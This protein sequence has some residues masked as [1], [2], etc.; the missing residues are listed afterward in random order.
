MIRNLLNLLEDL[1]YR[2]LCVVFPLGDLG[3]HEVD[4]RLCAPHGTPCCE[5][6]EEVLAE[7]LASWQA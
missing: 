5:N 7:V 4:L 1:K 2:V 3:V 6:E